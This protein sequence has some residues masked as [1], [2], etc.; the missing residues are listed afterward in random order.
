M[1]F[2]FFHLMP[3]RP[4]DIGR[5]DKHAFG[6]VVLPNTIYDPK[7]GADRIPFLLDQLAYAEKLGFD[8]DRGQRTSP[9]RLR[10]DAGAGL[11]A[12]L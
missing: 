7:K 1:Q 5:A 2:I 11:I 3:Y 8:G 9:D 6:W 12:A 4:M 10:H